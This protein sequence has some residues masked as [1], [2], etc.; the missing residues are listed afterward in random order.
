MA[1]YC[2]KCGEEFSD[3]RDLLNCWCHDGEHHKP[4]EGHET[5][6]FHCGKCGE[7]FSDLRDLLNCWCHDGEHHEPL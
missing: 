7:E 6:P 4:Y 1:Y 3:L 2:K 5:G